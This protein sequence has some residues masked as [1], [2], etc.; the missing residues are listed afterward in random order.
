MSRTSVPDD[1]ELSCQ[2]EFQR[3]CFQA[4]QAEVF[5]P[6]QVLG[7]KA[8]V[9]GPLQ[10]RAECNLFHASQRRAKQKCAPAPKARCRLSCRP[11]RDGRERQTVRDHDLHR[12]HHGNHRLLFANLTRTQLHVVGGDTVRVLASSLISQSVLSQTR[13]ATDRAA[14]ETSDQ[15]GATDS[16]YRFRSDSGVASCPPTARR[17][18]FAMIDS[19][20]RCCAVQLGR[21]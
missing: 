3:Q 19:S 5:S 18:Q 10:K 11:C 21:N 6:H 17:M 4:A 9:R 8:D 14:I 7:S 15:G 20:L 16:A 12:C 2:F 13:G 1:V